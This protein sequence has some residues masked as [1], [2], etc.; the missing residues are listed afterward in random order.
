MDA[1]NVVYRRPI[2]SEVRPEA[3]EPIKERRFSDPTRIS[4]WV[5]EILRFSWM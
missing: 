2:E 4:T 5:D 1:R 3:R